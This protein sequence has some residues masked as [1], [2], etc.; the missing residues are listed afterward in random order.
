MRLW[1]GCQ[2]AL[3]SIIKK[4]KHLLNKKGYAGAISMNLSKAFDTINHELLL[5]RLYAYDFSKH[6]L[7]VL[8]SY[9]SIRRQRV[10]INNTFSSSK[11]LIQGVLQGSGLAS[12][13]FNVYL[14]DL[15]FTLRNTGICNFA[16]DSTPYICD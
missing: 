2:T 6:S 8:S 4:W 5:A 3:A 16:D 1:K 11:N 14:N 12:L 9:V 15:F 13:I 7:L 10:K